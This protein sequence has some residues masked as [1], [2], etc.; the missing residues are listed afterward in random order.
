M[1]IRQAYLRRHLIKGT[2]SNAERTSA[3]Q[4]EET[5]AIMALIIIIIIITVPVT[6]PIT[7]G[8]LYPLGNTHQ[9]KDVGKRRAIISSDLTIVSR[10]LRS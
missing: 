8:Q 1:H 7:T 5:K 9:A 6:L 4:K 3:C 10:G 2:A